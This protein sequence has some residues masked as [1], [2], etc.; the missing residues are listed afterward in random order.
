MKF[1]ESQIYEIIDKALEV[2]IAYHQA[3]Q[4]TSAEIINLWLLKKVRERG[5]G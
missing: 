1:E 4:L 5:R 3:Y 2:G